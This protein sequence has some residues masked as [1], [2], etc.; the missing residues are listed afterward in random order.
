LLSEFLSH[1]GFILYFAAAWGILSCVL[2][3]RYLRH[4]YLLNRFG[5][6]A[7]G[8]IVDRRVSRGKSAACY[9]SIAFNSNNAAGDEVHHEVEQV[10][11]DSTYKRLAKGTPVTVR[12][13]S[14]NPKI[15]RLTGKYKDDVG[16]NSLIFFFI[17]YI[18]GFV[19]V[20]LFTLT[21]YLKR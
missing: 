16:R 7:R 3:I 8:Y 4:A 10:V 9:V 14:M 5:K 1:Y 6:T 18:A 17:I 13:A 20:V 19:F 11:G 15:A 21:I 12:Y 2:L